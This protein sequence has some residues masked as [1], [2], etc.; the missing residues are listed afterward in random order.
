MIIWLVAESG[1]ICT[2]PITAGPMNTPASRKI[3]TSG[4]F[5]MRASNPANTPHGQDDAEHKQGMFGEFQGAALLAGSALQ[6]DAYHL[7]ITYRL[8]FG[9]ADLYPWCVEIFND[10][11]C[12]MLGQG[13]Q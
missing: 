12:D 10:D 13:F 5:A 8:Q 7:A 11:L 3:T 9:N 2:Q 4:I 6:G 1:L